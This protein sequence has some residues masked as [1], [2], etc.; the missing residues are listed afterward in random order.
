[1]IDILQHVSGGSKPAWKLYAHEMK[2]VAGPFVTVVHLLLRLHS[3]IAH[4]IYGFWARTTALFSFTLAFRSPAAAAFTLVGAAQMAVWSRG[5][6]KRYR[7]KF[8]QE[9]AFTATK[10]LIP[11][12]F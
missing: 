6:L 5:K 12:V 3:K 2:V 8:Y 4:L 10:A 1:M 11:F 7:R 9:D